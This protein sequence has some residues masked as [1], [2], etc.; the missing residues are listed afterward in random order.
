MDYDGTVL[1]Q[2]THSSDLFIK[3]GGMD[4]MVGCDHQAH[5]RRILDRV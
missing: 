4:M 1:G 5:H 2:G 3:E